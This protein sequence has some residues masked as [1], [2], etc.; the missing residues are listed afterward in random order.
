MDDPFALYAPER[1]AE[2]VNQASEL[3]DL[4]VIAAPPLVDAGEAHAICAAAD[5]TILVLEE[6]STRSRDALVACERLSRVHADVQ[7]VVLAHRSVGRK[8]P[9]ISIEPLASAP[10]RPRPYPLAGADAEM[11]G[12]PQTNG[13]AQDG[14]D[15]R[16]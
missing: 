16:A 8:A 2:L 1:C 3:A 15:S 13:A 14:A 10:R 6:N 12:G 5:R 4:V 11:A 9:V 7:G